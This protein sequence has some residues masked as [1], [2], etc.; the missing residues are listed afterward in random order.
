MPGVFPMECFWHFCIYHRNSGFSC[1][2]QWVFVS[3]AVGFCVR[4]SGFSCPKQW[5]FDSE[6][7]Y[8]RPRRSVP[9]A[10]KERPFGLEEAS[11]LFRK[12]GRIN[13]FERQRNVVMNDIDHYDH[14]DILKAV[15]FRASSFF[16]VSATQLATNARFCQFPH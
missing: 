1:P 12:Y 9:S 5:V 2:K 3:E 14:A 13:H 7:V 8:L 10:S 16:S 11:L 4:S 6:A 15:S